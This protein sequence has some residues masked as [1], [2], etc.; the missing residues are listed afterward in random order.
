M[1][2]A[3]TDDVPFDRRSALLARFCGPLIDLEIVLEIAATVDP[4]DTGTITANAFFH[5]SPDA[6]QQGVCLRQ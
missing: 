2:A 6:S 1:A 4:I 5:H 3:L